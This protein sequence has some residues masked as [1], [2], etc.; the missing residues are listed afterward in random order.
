MRGCLTM[1]SEDQSIDPL[2]SSSKQTKIP[3]DNIPNLNTL[4][5]QQNTQHINS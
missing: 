1:K 5:I 2:P 4:E 3:N